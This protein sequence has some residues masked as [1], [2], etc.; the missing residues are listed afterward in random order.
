MLLWRIAKETPKYPADDMSG[1]GAAAAGGRWNLKTC[2]VVYASSSIALACLET[3]AHI[4]TGIAA[5]NRYLI[6]ITVPPRV[7]KA[8]RT[9]P[10][11]ELSPQWSAEPP[12]SYSMA[13]GTE[14]AQEGSTALL[15]VPS[16][17]I[18]EETNVLV[19]PN[20]RD[21]KKITAR[22]VRQFVYDPRLATGEPR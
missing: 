6:E 18:P 16:V 8:R 12:G 7:W 15:V 9:L 14:W 21:A 19:N 13:L 5:R 3:L 1:G 20:H 4:G 2:P 11:A 22:V 17:L 10:L